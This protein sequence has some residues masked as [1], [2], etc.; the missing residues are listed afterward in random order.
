MNEAMAT[1]SRVGVEDW[2]PI[3][4]GA[5]AW[6]AV[7]SHSVGA[8]LVARIAELPEVTRLPDLNLRSSGVA[9][10]LAPDDGAL[11]GAISAAARELGLVAEPAALQT[12]QV[13]IDAAD[14]PSVTSFWQAALG[15]ER[16]G[17]DGLADPLRRAPA[18]RVGRLDEPRQ[19]RNRIHLDAVWAP[20][21]VQTIKT[22]LGG[23]TYGAFDLTLADS[24]G[25]EVDLVPGGK[26]PAP[27][28][29]DWRAVFGAMA[30]YPTTSP[31]QAARL[32]TST[33]GLADDAGVPLMVDLRAEGVVIDSGKDGWEDDQGGAD[34][35][36][37]ELAG[38]IQSA[39]H[40]LELVADPSRPHFLQ[41]G[42]DAVDLP[43]VRAFWAA[44]LGYQYDPRTHV[45]DIYDPRRLNP[46][47][48]FQEMDP[49]DQ[50][51]RRQRNRIHLDLL[52]PDEV[53]QSRVDT[54]VAAGGRVLAE[55]P[56][57]RT[58][59]DPE[60]NEVDLVSTS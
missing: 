35:R 42:I 2:R 8:A 59:A 41:F 19:L 48:F 17:A 14:P 6:F 15:Y 13:A 33:A 49:A 38:R 29:S 9:V 51:R 11:A 36:F 60:G 22:A 7:P 39:A 34:S 57:R 24:E 21:A 20:E 37:V 53:L 3:G 16:T 31:A 54:A 1:G 27:E 50:D 30:F 58:I 4:T 5:S 52:V 55:V 18:V 23:Q 44:L 46:E 32:A 43:A 10:R 28:A 12:L 45:T 56:G 40:D 25:N 47:L 26:L